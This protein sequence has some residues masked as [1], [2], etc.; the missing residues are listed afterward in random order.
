MMVPQILRFTIAFVMVLGVAGTAAAQDE[1]MPRDDD[2]RL[3]D[4]QRDILPILRDRCLECHNAEEA[5][6]D[7]RVD[8]A[9]EFMYYVEPED[10]E[11]SSVFADYM[12]TDDPDMLMP[13]RSQGGPLSSAELTLMATW[14]NEGAHWPEGV[15]VR[16]VDDDTPI[17]QAIEQAADVAL[18]VASRVWSF[19]GFFH[20]AT[21]HFPIA[22]LLVGALFV[23][24]GWRWPT[25]GTQVPAACLILGALTAVAATAMGWSFATEKGYAGWTRVDFDSEV[26]WHRWGGVIVTVFACVSAFIAIV[27]LRSDKPHL[28][29]VWKGGLLIVAMMVGMVGHQGGELTYGKDFYPK[30]FRIL[31]GTSEVDETAS[32]AEETE[33]ESD[34]EDS[35]VA[36]TARRPSSTGG[37]GLLPR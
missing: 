17:E 21:V 22:L 29:K 33:G 18:P 13:P 24:L 26:F 32:G 1:R 35:P 27:A 15:V 6:N 3:V 4:F 12:A 5:K 2:G 25:I 28:N 16:A 19:Q 7:F 23:V 31:L 10:A 9:E 8:D 20:P 30:A 14:I 37:D 34:S 11:S 36:A